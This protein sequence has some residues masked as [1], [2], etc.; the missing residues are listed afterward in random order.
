MPKCYSEDLRWRIVFIVCL[1]GK[2]IQVSCDTYVSHSTVERLLHLY[3]T[4]GDVRSLQDKHGPERKLSEFEELTILQSFLNNPGIYLKVQEELLDVTRTW[5]SCATVCRTR[6]DIT[7]QKM[8]KIAIRCSEALRA[9]YMAEIEAFDP[10]MLVFLDETGCDRRNQIRQFGYGLRGIT[11]VTHKLVT[12][13]KRIS[14]IDVMT[15]RGIED[16]YLVEG[17]VNTEIFLQFVQRCLLNIIEPFDGN[18]ARSVVML[19]NASIHHLD[20]V[21][22]LITTGALDFYPPTVQT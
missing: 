2:T 12:Y 16:V 18:N 17:N 11:P 6:L 14:A 15:T 20:A 13:G 5:V 7:R 4:T 1:Q 10:D 21:V 3:R 9:K 22:D 8:K 19:D